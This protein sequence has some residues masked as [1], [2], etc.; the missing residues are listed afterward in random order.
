MLAFNSSLKFLANRRFAMVLGNQLDASE[1]VNA[2]ARVVRELARDSQASL[3]L[4]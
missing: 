4:A 2:K 3:S 1:R